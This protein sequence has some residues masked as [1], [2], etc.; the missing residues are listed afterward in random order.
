MVAAASTERKFGNISETSAVYVVCVFF[1]LTYFC[2]AT[3]SKCKD[4]FFFKSINM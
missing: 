4:L 1:L 2:I 3:E